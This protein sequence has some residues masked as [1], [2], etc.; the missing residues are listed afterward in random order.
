MS[1]VAAINPLADVASLAS[2]GLAACSLSGGKWLMPAHLARIDAVVTDCLEGHGPRI[3]I[4][5]TPPRHGKSEYFSKWLPFW[6]LCMNPDKRVAL[7]SYEAH[8]ARSWGRKVRQLMREHGNWFGLEVSR[9]Q[10][11]ASDWAIAR[12]SGGMITTGVGGP[13]TGRGADLLIVDDPIKN[14]EESLSQTVRD[15]HWDWWQSTASTRIEPGGLAIIVATRWHVD[16]LSGRL[17]AA[18]D[19]EEG[20][21]ICRIHLPAIAEDD[22]W[23]GRPPGEALW[24]E[25]WSRE[26]MNE[27]RLSLDQYWWGALY[28]QAPGRHGS[29][30]W[31]D[32]YFRD[33]IWCEESS[34]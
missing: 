17:I 2:P 8:F 31:P 15:A 20:S 1:C 19:T 10:S 33:E 28:Q 9:E 25:R 12:R 27:R 18:A 3:L 32:E 4:V 6:F 23:M 5:E 21:P 14:A 29:M 7:T 24:P 11:S 30:E 16:D 26:A 13:L 22:D 34:P